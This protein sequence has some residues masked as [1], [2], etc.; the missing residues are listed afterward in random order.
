MLP[1]HRTFFLRANRAAGLSE[2]ESIS[3]TRLPLFVVFNSKSRIHPV[4]IAKFGVQNDSKLLKVEHHFRVMIRISDSHLLNLTATASGSASFAWLIV[5]YGFCRRHCES[6]ADPLS[7]RKIPTCELRSPSLTHHSRW[8]WP[9]GSG[10]R[11]GRA[12]G[13][14]FPSNDNR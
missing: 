10:P 2:N 3:H 5:H 8:V 1:H 7:N 14:C 6:P 4:L 13:G 12:C 11:N 9:F